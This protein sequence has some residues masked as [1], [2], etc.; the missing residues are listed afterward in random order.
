MV[1]LGMKLR[2]VMRHLMD[3]LIFCNGFANGCPWD[4]WT[5]CQQQKWP[6]EVLNG[7]VLMDAHGTIRPVQGEQWPSDVQWAHANGCEDSN[8]LFS[9]ANGH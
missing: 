7:H 4:H 2:A 1:V 3:I 5:C 6:S 9:S 8:L